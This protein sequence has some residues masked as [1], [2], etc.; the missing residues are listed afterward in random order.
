M[1]SESSGIFF[2]Q[3]PLFFTFEFWEC[4]NYVVGV[5]VC[6]LGWPLRYVR[7]S[8][9]VRFLRE[10][11]ILFSFHVM[12]L[13]LGVNIFMEVSTRKGIELKRGSIS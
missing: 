10:F 12:Y 8:H 9:F 6:P 4:Y 11:G 2:A 5:L 7:F 3:I 13:V 1:L